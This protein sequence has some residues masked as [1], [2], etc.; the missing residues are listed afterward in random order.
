MAQI[1]V[2]IYKSNDHIMYS[3]RYLRFRVTKTKPREVRNNPMITN[4]AAR[5]K[6]DFIARSI[7]VYTLKL[8]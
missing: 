7:D 3:F 4:T 2:Y 5:E 1:Y 8:A 6:F